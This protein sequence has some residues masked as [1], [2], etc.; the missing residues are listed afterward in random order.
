MKET[1]DNF[2][3]PEPTPWVENQGPQLFC[4]NGQ[5]WCYKESEYLFLAGMFHVD[6]VSRFY[7]RS[8][9]LNLLNST[10]VVS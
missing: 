2:I 8:I 4:S 10:N 7:T 1:L 6:D 5:L 3:K 9:I